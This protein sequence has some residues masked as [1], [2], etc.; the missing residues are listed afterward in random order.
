[1]TLSQARKLLPPEERDIS[2]EKL[3]DLLASMYELADLSIDIY[4][5]RRAMRDPR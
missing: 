4:L 2:D 1:M 5:E 3:T